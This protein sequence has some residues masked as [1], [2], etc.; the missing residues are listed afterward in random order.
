[1]RVRHVHLVHDKDTDRFKGFCYVE[2]EELEDLVKA[3][4]LN[5]IMQVNKRFIK[6]D[7]AE[8]KRSDRLD[9]F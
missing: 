3:L 7:I 9:C 6:I 2:F 4:D 1:M 5:N 8:G